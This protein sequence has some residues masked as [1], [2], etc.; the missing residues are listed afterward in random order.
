VLPADPGSAV[1][2]AV[3]DEKDVD[4]QPPRLVRKPGEHRSD[5]GLLVTRDDDGETPPPDFNR[6]A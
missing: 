1:P 5:G 4:R 6:P 3:V 2:R